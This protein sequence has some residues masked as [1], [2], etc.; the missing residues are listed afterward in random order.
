MWSGIVAP[1]S[2]DWIGLYGP[3]TAD[4]AFL[5]WIYV[6]CSQVAGMPKAEGSCLFA[7]PGSLAPGTYE[8]RVLAN[9]GYTRLGTSNQ[10]TVTP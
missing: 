10:F 5:A 4:T 8:L 9:N 2:M 1:T 3:G 7:L 6:S